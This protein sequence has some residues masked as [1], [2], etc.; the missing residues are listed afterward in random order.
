M[1]SEYRFLLENLKGKGY[2]GDK[3]IDKRILQ[4]VLGSKP[5]TF[6]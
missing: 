4:M 3:S 2:L 1:K 6:L 5:P